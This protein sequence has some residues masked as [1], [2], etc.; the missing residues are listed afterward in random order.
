MGKRYATEGERLIA[1]REAR[2]R[3]NQRYYE[4]HA[5]ILKEREKE[6][7]FG[8]YQN[9]EVFRE[10]KQQKSRDRYH[11]LKTEAVK[12]DEPREP[13]AAENSGFL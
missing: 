5:E 2:K 13:A 6:R 7:Q 12:T 11:A 10:R 1:H 4:K 9:D 8:L 3:Q